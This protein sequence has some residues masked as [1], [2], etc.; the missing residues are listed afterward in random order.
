MPSATTWMVDAPSVR[1]LEHEF[2]G[3]LPAGA[4]L[5]ALTTA[6]EEL[7]GSIV[8]E[9]LAQMA[10]TLARFRLERDAAGG[11]GALAQLGASRR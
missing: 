11:A 6:V 1:R 10:F 4:A 7:T 9:A 5:A 3:R 8:R 2:E